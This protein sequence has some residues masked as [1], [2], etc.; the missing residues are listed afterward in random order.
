MN[1]LALLVLLCFVSSVISQTSYAPFGL[2]LMTTAQILPS[3]I[4]LPT[5]EPNTSAEGRS[6]GSRRPKKEKKN[7]EGISKN[8]D[9]SDERPIDAE[10]NGGG[11][12]EASGESG[13]ENP[14]PQKSK[15]PAEDTSPPLEQANED[16]KGH[17]EENA[18]DSSGEGE[19]KEDAKETQDTPKRRNAKVEMVESPPVDDC[20]DDENNAPRGE[21][22]TRKKPREEKSQPKHKGEERDPDPEIEASWH[23]KKPRDGVKKTSTGPLGQFPWIP[24]GDDVNPPDQD[25]DD[26]DDE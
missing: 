2:V 7:S 24:P 18:E 22:A 26:D 11:N 3:A 5:G 14:E 13:G 23:T 9:C 25:D 6:S 8:E 15:E 1:H 17:T 21:V 10:K 4:L 16:A 12:I 19:M 20:K